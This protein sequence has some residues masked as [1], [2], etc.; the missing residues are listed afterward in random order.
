MV[1]IC[2]RPTLRDV[3]LA[4][5][6]SPAT[7]SRV[8]AGSRNVGEPLAS[9]V[10]EAAAQLDYRPNSAARA[11]RRQTTDTVGMVVPN[12]V[13]PFFPAVVQAVEA[14]L[15][16]SGRSLLLCD[17]QD[18]HALEA[19]R[20]QALL[21]RD[22]EALLISPVDSVASAV[23]VRSAAGRVRVVQIDRWVDAPTDKVLVD[24][25]A[26]IAAVVA[27][28][29]GQGRRR[30][31]F[32][33]SSLSISTAVERLAAYREGVAAHGAEGAERILVGDFSLGWG[34]E[35]G[36]H[37]AQSRATLPDAVVCANDLIALGVVQALRRA[38]LEVPGEVAVTGFDD[39][40]LAE[41]GEIPLTTVR[42]PFEAVGLEAVRLLSADGDGRVPP[43]RRLVLEPTLVVRESTG[44]PA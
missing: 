44:G 20:V 30:L 31:A 8:L 13:N 15:A 29:V 25:A 27:H 41:L 24:Q 22:I 32:V 9:T 42:Q 14:A 35:A 36:E 11:L 38:G 28:L 21:A 39:T 2:T 40:S 4:A 12:I 43:P 19:R 26:G 7:V 37:L 6:V 16:A 23:T 1:Q 33:T 17:A 34:R 5:G 10:R 18:D 3:A